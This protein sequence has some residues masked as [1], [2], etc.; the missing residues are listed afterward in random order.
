[1]QTWIGKKYN[2]SYSATRMVFVN[3]HT[4]YFKKC[5]H[6][7]LEDGVICTVVRWHPV[8]VFFESK[9]AELTQTTTD[10]CSRWCIVVRI[11]MQ[12]CSTNSRTNDGWWPF[13]EPAV[14]TQRRVTS[15]ADVHRSR[16]IGEAE[17]GQYDYC[18]WWCCYFFNATPSRSS[19]NITNH[20]L[21]RFVSLSHQQ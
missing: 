17:G 4:G 1:M 12:L 20:F 3:V 19:D 18:M 11:Q 16:Q 14:W 10:L 9:M 2:W 5:F 15:H 8:D 21:P 7:L 13:R 6:T